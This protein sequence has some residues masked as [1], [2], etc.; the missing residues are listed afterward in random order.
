MSFVPSADEDTDLHDRALSRPVQVTP[1][2]D[3][4]K[5]WSLSATATN[6][7]PSA[8]DATENQLRFVSRAVQL[9]PE[10]AEV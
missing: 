5:I 2:S 9:A 7:V 6:L 10:S 1:E 4:V 8:D 3:E